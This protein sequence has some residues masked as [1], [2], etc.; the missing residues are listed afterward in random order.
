[1]V[2]GDPETRDGV[3]ITLHDPETRMQLM[4]SNEPDPV[5]E[6]ETLPPGVP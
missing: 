2:W 1:M 6:K 3:Y 5:E 4:L